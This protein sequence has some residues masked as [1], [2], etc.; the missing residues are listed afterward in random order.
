MPQLGIDPQKLAF[1]NPEGADRPLRSPLGAEV[2]ERA[3]RHRRA[4][5]RAQLAAHDCAAALLYDPVN[6]RYALD[7]PNMQLWTL[8]N[9][10]RYAL[11]LAD[12]PAI[13]FE[14]AGCEHLAD[15]RDDIDQIRPAIGWLFMATGSSQPARVEDWADEID[16]LLREHGGGN[17]RLA[18][19]K[20]ELPGLRALE[21]RGVACVD[22]QPLAETARAIKS[23]DEVELMRWSVRV[24]E[25]GLAR[26]W[27]ASEPGRTEQEIWAALQHENA[28]S[29]GEWLETR[30]L[31]AGPRTNPWYGECSDYVCQEGQIIAVDTDMIGP[32]GYCA[33]LSRSWTCGHTPFNATQRSLYAAALEQINHNVALLRPGLRFMEFIEKSWRIPPR[34]QERRYGIA[35]HGV[36][37]VDEWPVVP[38]HPSA[39]Q[40]YDGVFEE[41][42][43]VCVESLIGAEGTECVKLETQVLITAGGAVRLDSFPWENI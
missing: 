8:R 26:L 19:D 41:N 28:R 5:L 42:M 40:A 32:Y 18:I 2:L 30:L 22:G 7:T 24:C 39:A 34:F 23:A 1:L 3:R 15:G 6:I 13:L 11:V 35:L 14:L 16:S 25:A 4:R 10:V 27:Q 21:R 38:D 12:G 37:L 20:L 29:G 31:T 9:A 43:T 36:G 33:D 17:R